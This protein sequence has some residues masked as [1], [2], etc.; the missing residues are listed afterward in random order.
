VFALM[1]RNHD[2]VIAYEDVS[3]AMEKHKVFQ[4]E[5]ALL[6]SKEF[7]WQ[8]LDHHKVAIIIVSLIEN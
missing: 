6:K 8:I 2:E 7:I 5:E 3:Y 1:D 4:H